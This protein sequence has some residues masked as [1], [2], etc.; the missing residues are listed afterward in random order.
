MVPTDFSLDGFLFSSEEGL[1]AWVSQALLWG[2]IAIVLTAVLATYIASLNRRLS[3]SLRTMAA[4]A[5]KLEVANNQ[6]ARLSVT[7]PLTGLFNRRYF[8][9]TLTIELNR[10]SRSQ[11]PMSLL[12]LDVDLFKTYND[13]FGHPAG[14]L[15]LKRVAEVLRDHARRGGEFAARIGGEEFAVVASNVGS[16]EAQ[17]L[18][19]RILRWLAD[20]KLPHP[21]SP[22]GVVTVSIGTSTHEPGR[23]Q[24]LQELLDQADKALYLAKQAGRNRCVAYSPSIATGDAT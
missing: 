12:M 20:L 2:A 6:L 21:D 7:D 15:C 23:G 8:D 1:P 4:Q 14:D 5:E 16:S 13:A 24:T 19:E 22:F 10:A 18:A 11:I 17:A 3:A 9:A